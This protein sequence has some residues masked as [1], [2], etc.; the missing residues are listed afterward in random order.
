MAKASPFRARLLPSFKARLLFCAR[1]AVSAAVAAAVAYSEAATLFEAFLLVPIIAIMA[2]APTT[3]ESIALFRPLLVGCVIATVVGLP[4]GALVI[5]PLAVMAQADGAGAGIVAAS[6]L[7]TATCL[8]LVTYVVGSNSSRLHRAELKLS[9]ALVAITFVLLQERG[10]EG[11]ITLPFHLML[12]VAAGAALPIIA[13][14]A[15]WPQFAMAQADAR[16]QRAV[17]L[18]IIQVEAVVNALVSRQTPT[19][20]HKGLVREASLRALPVDDSTPREYARIEYAAG[21]ARENLA[22]Y[23][24]AIAAARYEGCPAGVLAR[25]QLWHVRM[26]RMSNILTVCKSQSARQ[27]KIRPVPLTHTH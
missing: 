27:R 17:T 24:K 3:G 12:A 20:R 19:R 11:D 9:L 1:G 16:L 26:T 10:A 8:A 4:L 23:A 21:R 22:A 25:H 5:K 14:L 6:S 15:P 2:T 13:G 7:V 18:C